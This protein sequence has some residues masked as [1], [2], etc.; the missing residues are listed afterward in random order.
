MDSRP[1]N[2]ETATEPMLSDE[3]LLRALVIVVMVLSLI[4]YMH[5]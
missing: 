3:R 2:P 5:G 1:K 4:G